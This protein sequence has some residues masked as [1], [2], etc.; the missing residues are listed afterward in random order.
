LIGL[1]IEQ[2]DKCRLIRT[3]LGVAAQ[4]S[5]QIAGNL[6]RTNMRFYAD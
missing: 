2:I 5:D 4:R 6:I 3:L 1:A